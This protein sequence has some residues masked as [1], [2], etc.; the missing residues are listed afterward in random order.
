MI[1]FQSARINS[2]DIAESGARS[3]LAYPNLAQLECLPQFSM[4]NS[5]SNPIAIPRSLMIREQP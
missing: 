3:G 4:K 1:D 2:E 5:G